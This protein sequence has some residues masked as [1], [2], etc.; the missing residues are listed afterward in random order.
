MMIGG[1][2]VTIGGGGGAETGGG[3]CGGGGG[4]AWSSISLRKLAQSVP[5]GK[6]FGD[7]PKESN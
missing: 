1:G 2:G 4:D 5:S 7:A 3:C 6:K